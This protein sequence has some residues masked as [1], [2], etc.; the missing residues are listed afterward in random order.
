LIRNLQEQFE[1]YKQH[2]KK[3]EQQKKSVGVESHQVGNQCDI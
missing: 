2:A 1:S 3:G